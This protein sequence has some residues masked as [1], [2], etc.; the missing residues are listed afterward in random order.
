MI[1]RVFS[2]LNRSMILF[3]DSINELTMALTEDS[4]ISFSFVVFLVLVSYI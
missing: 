1:L 3:Y 4:M 2:N